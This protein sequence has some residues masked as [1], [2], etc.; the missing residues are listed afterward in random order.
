[1]FSYIRLPNSA[2]A[3]A[4]LTDPWDT[5]IELMENLAPAAR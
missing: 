1:M 3:I 2:T 5:Y 4:F